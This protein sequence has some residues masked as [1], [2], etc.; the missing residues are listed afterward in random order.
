MTD[1]YQDLRDT[2]P[3]A[4]E[5]ERDRAALSRRADEYNTAR[6]HQSLGMDRPADRFTPRPPDPQLP[7]RIPP[8]LATDP[9][10]PAPVRLPRP[11][12]AADDQPVAPAPL[13][14][15]ANGVDPVNLAVE[16]TRTV[17]ASGNLGLGGQ[18]FWLGPA[19][20]GRSLV[21]WADT[22]VVHLL[23]DGVRLKTV[24]SRLTPAHLRQLLADGGRPAGPP[25][26]LPGP[27]RPGTPIEVD[28]LVN[29]NGLVALAGRQHSVGIQFAGRRVTVRLDR[30][31]LQLAAGGILLRSLPNPLTTADLT[32]LRDAR[33]AGP[34][35]QPPTEPVRVERRISSRGALA[36]AGQKIHVGIVHAG[37][38]VTVEQ[39]DG[40][41]RI[42]DGDQ[43]LTE[44]PRTTT[45]PIARFKAHKPE[46]PRTRR[47][48]STQ[49]DDHGA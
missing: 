31:V 2:P 28:R 46:P 4:G 17:P 1:R 32:R 37:R 16:I 35:P 13:V 41:F 26:I 5:V 8:T 11:R 43:L 9:A 18:Q 12:P 36:V 29:A 22:T 3:R 38:T 34:P 45:K 21:L 42:Y 33:P 30:G 44:V 14:M 24:P 19:H 23:L 10:A 20:A 6:P 27:I 47:V 39:G 15:S 49:H 48:A 25:P 40:T 7:L